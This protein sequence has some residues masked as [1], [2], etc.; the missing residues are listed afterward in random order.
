MKNSE[1]WKPT[2]I[3]LVA[4]PICLFLG[5]ISGGVGH[6]NYIIAKILFP[7]MIL[8]TICFEK[9][10]TPFIV[11]A[12]LQIPF[13]GVI[14]GLAKSQ[15]IPYFFIILLVTI[16]ILAVIFCFIFVKGFGFPYN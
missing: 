8:S 11:L 14:L 3:S 15:K 16:H 7:F 13:Y 6:G 4:T 12:V 1:F 2:I 9:I 10:T 5:I